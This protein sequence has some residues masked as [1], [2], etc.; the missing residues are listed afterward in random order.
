MQVLQSLWAKLAKVW[1]NVAQADGNPDAG[2]REISQSVLPSLLRL[3]RDFFPVTKISL[4]A[5]KK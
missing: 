5:A 2:A 3:A 4:L 1:G